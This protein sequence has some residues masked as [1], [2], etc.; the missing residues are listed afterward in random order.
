MELKISDLTL[1]SLNSVKRYLNKQGKKGR[2][3][4]RGENNKFTFEECESL[5]GRWEI[6]VSDDSTV[7]TDIKNMEV[8]GWKS[9]GKWLIDGK[10]NYYTIFYIDDRSGVIPV[11]VKTKEQGE[12]RKKILTV[13]VVWFA[14]WI[15]NV[16]RMSYDKLQGLFV[17]KYVIIDSLSQ[18]YNIGNKPY[19]LDTVY[20][21]N[22]SVLIWQSLL[23]LVL[24]IVLLI[25]VLSVVFSFLI[26]R[27]HKT[28]KHTVVK[29]LLVP[30][31]ILFITAIAVVVLLILLINQK[32]V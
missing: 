4:V 26:D 32:L 8:Y 1:F 20:T 24:D 27:Y 29:R 3:F 15:A 6:C 31:S 28:D 11:G 10:M 23:A 13:V 17:D 18:K 5:N 30:L 21:S 14:I 7:E 2:R 19:I 22:V 25:C 16:L 12:A 9:M